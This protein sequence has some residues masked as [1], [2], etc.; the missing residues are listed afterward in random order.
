LLQL[1]CPPEVVER[2]TIAPKRRQNA[3]KLL[4]IPRSRVVLRIGVGESL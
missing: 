4:M 2:I 1:E 3:G